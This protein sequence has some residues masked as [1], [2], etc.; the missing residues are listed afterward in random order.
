[1]G[2]FM[3]LFINMILKSA[4]GDSDIEYYRILWIDSNYVNLVW[5]YLNDEKQCRNMKS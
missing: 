5:I 2:A 3:S 1:M 4:N